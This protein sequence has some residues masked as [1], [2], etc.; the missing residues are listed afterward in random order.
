MKRADVL[1]TALIAVTLDRQNTHGQPEDSFGTIAKFWST[2]LGVS[3]SKADVALMLVLLKVARAGQNPE[4]D[5]NWVDI[6]G[7]A[8]CGAEVVK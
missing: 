1:D 3:V 4:H 5:D 8:A 2:H 6:A 7:Y